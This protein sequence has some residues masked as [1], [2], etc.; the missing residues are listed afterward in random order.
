MRK[1]LLCCALLITAT[2]CAMVGPDY[3]R[4]AV[5]VPAA[6]RIEEKEALD[7][8][9]TAWW[10]Q[11]ND[12]VLNGLVRTALSENKDLMIA[13]ARVEEFFGRYFS[14]RGDQ[15]PF[16]DAGAS[17]SRERVTEVGPT[18]IPS[19]VDS[20]FDYYE[21]FMSARWEIDFWGKYRRASE[22]ARAE[23]FSTEEAR[24]TV[25]LTLVSA[26]AGAYVEIRALDKQL[27]ITR[28]TVKTRL[29]TL[30]LFK[31]R[32]D[33]GIIPEIDVSQAEAEYEDA[34]ARVPEIEL[35]IART[36]NALSILTG[37]NPGPIPRGLTIDELI[38]PAIPAGL[39]S[40][41][42]AR[43]PDIRAAEQALIAANARI[44]VAKSLYFP[45]I[46]LTGDLGTASADLSDLFSGRSKVWNV[47]VPLT[48][49]IFTAGRIGGEVKSAE[50]FRKQTLYDYLQTVQN[51]F[52][53][54]DD[55]LVNQKKS[56]QKLQSLVR[57]TRAL[58]NYARLAIMR[59]NEGVTSYLEVLDA[60]RSLFNVELSK[61]AGRNAMLQAL[62]DIY[63]SMGGG[64]VATAETVVNSQP[65][66][67]AG[68]IP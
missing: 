21:A 49:P 24:R 11:F 41:L 14:T 12:P 25:V 34:L 60:E 61:I 30:D 52:R 66:K 42:L 46:S 26:V 20:T 27:E 58:Q 35:A 62:I 57:Q 28:R 32:L 22:A 40:D 23:L 3:R 56:D 6:W 29:Q 15:F 16:P 67:S 65:V 55:A 33:R 53:E 44:G 43:R 51:A 17:A 48:V 45:T 18:P 36:E 2:G 68:Y 19:G 8:A 5:D 4:P 31:I 50:A 38:P 10:E 1:R 64:W 59:Y 39:P 37:R 54:V 47:G 7:L 63:K 13:T 9:D